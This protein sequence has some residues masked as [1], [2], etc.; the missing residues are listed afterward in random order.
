MTILGKSSGKNAGVEGRSG[1]LGSVLSGTAIL[2]ALDVG[3]TKISCVIAEYS[4]GKR[5]T[6]GDVR[7]ALKV[8]GFG[9]TASRGVKSG[10]IVD[11][12]D[13]ERAIRLAVDAAERMAQRRIRSV[14]V[15]VSGGRPQSLVCAGG[16]NSQTGVIS[17]RDGDNAVSDAISRIDVGRRHV[18]HLMPI[19][20][21]LDGAVGSN[22][23]LGLHG[24][25]LGAEVAVVTVDVAAMRNLEMVVERSHL[26]VSGFAL[27]P[28]AAARGALVSDE[29]S[30]GTLLIDMGGATTSFSL[31]KDGKM[32]SAGLLPLGGH[33]VTQD[34]AHGLS[35][36]I[37][38][39]ER[40][41]TMFG[42]VLPHGHDEREMLAVPLL[43]ERGVDTIQKVPK[44]VLT[45]IVR[46]RLEETFALLGQQLE[47]EGRFA[48]MATRVVLTGGAS[49]LQGVADLAAQ[50]LG[51]TVRLGAPSALAGMPD[52]GK[53]PGFSV[54]AGLLACA[55]EPDRTYAMPQQAREAID[56]SQL[57]YAKRVGRWLVESL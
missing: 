39:A 56:R 2:A 41:K 12:D 29:L 51:R 44:Q 33:H 47:E 21:S 35:T 20:F 55:A 57:S 25:E 6:S 30:L 4:P 50:M 15:G 48:K 9:Q 3:S 11:I 14:Y 53:G 10:T 7:S 23:P 38:H 24:A 34:I 13:A 8:V 52:V 28:Y 26:Q 40:L 46:P 49:Q 17:P 32:A 22:I 5:R 19:G 42:T 16:V 31:F 45:S 18:L 37:A 54:A 36:T 27:T 43:G 1:G